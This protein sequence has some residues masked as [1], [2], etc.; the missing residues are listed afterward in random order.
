[1]SFYLL[2]FLIL[3]ACLFIPLVFE[4]FTFYLYSVSNS[5]FFAFSG[6]RLWVFIIC[7][8]GLG[9][10][11]GF[12]HYNNTLQGLVGKNQ[13]SLTSVVIIAGSAFAISLL[14]LFVYQFCNPRQ[15]YYL[16]PD[17]L[18]QI[19][20]WVL[21]FVSLMAGLFTGYKIKEIYRE[22]STIHVNLSGP[23]IFFLATCI[24]IL[25]AYYPVSILYGISNSFPFALLMM[26]FAATVPFIPSSV[27]IFLNF[28]KTSLYAA[29]SGLTSS[30]L[31]ILL[32]SGLQTKDSQ[33]LIPVIIIPSAIV[34]PIILRRFIIR[35][36]I[37]FEVSAVHRKISAGSIITIFFLFFLSAAHPYMDAPMNL[38][39]TA[40]RHLVLTGYILPTYYIG[41]YFN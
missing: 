18:G 14:L 20:L 2:V 30:I 12:I 1:V 34:I 31:L 15:C 37:K 21:L 19:R 24:S 4:A 17:S 38:S 16:G 28:K 33:F 35:L 40:D 11:L 10:S 9:A 3:A 32:F 8:I 6:A 29:L 27:I 7:E 36:A 41:S 13:N 26:A 23:L 5:L 39:V 25:L 22:Q